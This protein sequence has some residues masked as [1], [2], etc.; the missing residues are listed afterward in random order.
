MKPIFFTS[1]TQLRQWFEEN[2]DTAQE[3]WVGYYKKGVAKPCITWSKSVDEALCISWID[4]IRQSIDQ[5][6]YANR[7]TPRK[8]KSNWSAVNIQKVEALTKMGR[9]KPAGLAAFNQRTDQNSR[10]YSFEQKMVQLEEPQL[11]KFQENERAWTYFKQQAASYQKQAIW[12]VVSAKQEETRLRRLEQLI[13]DS[14]QGQRLSQFR[15]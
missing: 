9:M 12:W 14:E 1:S 8:P 5:V 11:K 10:V 6:S 7:F 2:A 13:N 3:V 15:R 4:G